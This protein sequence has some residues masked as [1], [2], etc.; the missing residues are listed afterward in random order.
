MRPGELARRTGLSTDTLRHYERKG[1]L[2]ARIGVRSCNRTFVRLQ[3]LTAWGWRYGY[4]IWITASIRLALP[5][6][7]RT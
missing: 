4:L 2:A 3:D 1:L 5:P 7:A 6:R